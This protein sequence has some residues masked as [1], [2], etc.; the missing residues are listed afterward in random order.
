MPMSPQMPAGRPGLRVIS[1]Q[2]SPPSVDFH[3]PEFGPPEFSSHGLRYTCQN[4]AYSTF[5]LLG[6]ITRSTTPAESPRERILS[7]VLPPSFE[8]YT[9]R[10]EFGP[11]A[12]PSTPA[13]T[14]SGLV[15]FTTTSAICFASASPFCVHVLPPSV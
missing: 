11:N 3:I 13:Y 15:G 2:L 1:V 8:R 5:A 12:W 9:P 4:P 10:V 6:S 7:H 14:R